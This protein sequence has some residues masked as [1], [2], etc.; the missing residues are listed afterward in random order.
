MLYQVD[1]PFLSPFSLLNYIKHNY[2]Q[3]NMTD[4]LLEKLIE[5]LESK[6]RDCVS[7]SKKY[8][9][10]EMKELHQYYEG[11]NWAIDFVLATIK[12]L[13]ENH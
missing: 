6:K 2:W 11:A 9:T 10:R 13:K 5:V 8:E 1:F 4:E 12:E 3:T 7:F